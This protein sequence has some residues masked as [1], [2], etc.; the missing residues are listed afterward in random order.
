MSARGVTRNG[1]GS[2]RRR[3]VS[4]AGRPERAGFGNLRLDACARSA[5]TDGT[6]LK[7]PKAKDMWHFQTVNGYARNVIA[8]GRPK[9]SIVLCAEELGFLNF[10]LA[11]AGRV[12]RKGQ[13]TN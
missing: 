3:L 8:M 1:P 6:V 13:R 12:I 7:G 11:C 2:V 4:T 5:T 9:E 10:L